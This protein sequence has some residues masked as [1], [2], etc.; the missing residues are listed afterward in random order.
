MTVFIAVDNGPVWETRRGAAAETTIP[1]VLTTVVHCAGA[2]ALASRGG[3]LREK[4]RVG[5]R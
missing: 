4:G 1:A 5:V 3:T 2:I